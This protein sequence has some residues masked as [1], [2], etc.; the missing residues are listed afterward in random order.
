MCV[1]DLCMCNAGFKIDETGEYCIPECKS[2]CGIGGKCVAPG[3]CDCAEGYLVN[4]S[5]ICVL[6]LWW[7]ACGSGEFLRV[8]PPEGEI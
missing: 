4:S 1:D 2:G 5:V 8:G 6:P 7:S 3:Q